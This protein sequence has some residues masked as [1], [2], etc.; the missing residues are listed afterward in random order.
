MNQNLPPRT[1]PA[2][3]IIIPT[4]DHPDLLQRALASAQAQSYR[5]F[6]LIVVDDGDGS[7]AGLAEA[8]GLDHLQ[9]LLTGGSGHVPARNLGVAAA[10]GRRIAFLEDHDWWDSPDHLA[11]MLAGADKGLVYASGRI[12]AESERADAGSELA[13][14][15]HAD[16]EAIRHDNRLLV[17]G[18]IYPR[19]LHQNL[20][21]FDDKLPYY[22]DWDWYLRL[23]AA[24]VPFTGPLG[25]AVRIPAR[26]GRTVATNLAARQANLARLA[27]KHGLGQLVLRNLDSIAR[28][29]ARLGT[30]GLMPPPPTHPMKN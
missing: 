23:F 6:E 30:A 3:S 4:K 24:G 22:W 13:F 8:L 14:P 17:S 9:V 7:G 12:V 15:A 25:D 2:L 27:A 28:E 26:D 10:R 29:G 18:V 5:D 16:A 20:G 11:G 1:E 21:S 19:S